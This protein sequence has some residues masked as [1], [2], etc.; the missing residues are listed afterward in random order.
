MSQNRHVRAKT[1]NFTGSTLPIS[2]FF[3]RSRGK[4]AGSRPKRYLWQVQREV[5]Y[6]LHNARLW[7]REQLTDLQDILA[8]VKEKNNGK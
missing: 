4:H 3:A 6:Q 5:A 2:R 1:T 8:E 7:V